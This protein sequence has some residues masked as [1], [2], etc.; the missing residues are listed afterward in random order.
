[1]RRNT[2]SPATGVAALRTEIQS[3]EESVNRLKFPHKRWSLILLVSPTMIRLRS[4]IGGGAAPA[5]SDV[6]ISEFR[7]S[8]V[9]GFSIIRAVGL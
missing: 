8:S 3:L 1:M 5:S 7:L 2:A 4:S 6:S 9:C